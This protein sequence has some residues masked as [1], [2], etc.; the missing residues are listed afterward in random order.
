[1]LNLNPR[2]SANKAVELKSTRFMFNPDI[3]TITKTWLQKS[4]SDVFRGG[5]HVYRCDRA[6]IGGGVAL[7]VRD[8]FH[9]GSL[10]MTMFA[11][12]FGLP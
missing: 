4:D 2:S 8:T 3:A 1:M 12:W 5:F 7:L 11:K 10:N 6:E 9:A